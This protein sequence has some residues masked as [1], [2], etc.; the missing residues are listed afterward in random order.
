MAELTTYHRK[1]EG[2][3]HDDPPPSYSDTTFAQ[4]S[5]EFN[6]AQPSDPLLSNDIAMP[7]VA[8]G[9]DIAVLT[10]EDEVGIETGEKVVE[11]E[12]EEVS[13]REDHC[14]KAVGRVQDAVYGFF[15]GNSG[16]LWKIFYLVLLV[17]Y[18]VYFIAAMA[19]KFGDEGSI[20]LLVVTLLVSVY[21]LF[22][23]G[24]FLVRRGTITCCD[25]SGASECFMNFAKKIKLHMALPVVVMLSALIYIIVDVSLHHPRNLISLGGMV[26]F[27]LLF[28]VFSHNPARVQWRPVVWG[29]SLQFFFAVLILRTAWGYKAFDY[30]GARVTDLLAYTDAGSKFVFGNLYTNHFFAFK[31]LPVVVFF[32]TLVSMM[33]YVG[34]MQFIIRNLGRFLA[35]CLG[36]SPAESLNAAG[37]IFIGQSEAP[38]MI[39]PFISEMTKSELHAVLTGGFATIAGSVMAAFILYGVSPNHLLSAS[40]MSAPAALA[41][42]K[43]FYP[44]TKRTRHTQEEVYNMKRGEERN[45][46]DAASN[47]ATQSVKLVANI[48]VIL[49]AFIALLDFVNATLVWFGERV[50]VHDPKLTFQ[51]ISSYVFFPL[52]FLMGVDGE[53]GL[54][55]GELIGTKTF[56][57][58]FV[59]Y[60]EL[61][62]YINNRKTLNT[63]L[64]NFTLGL[65]TNPTGNYSFVDGGVFLADINQTL[66]KGLM[67]ERSVVI[68]TYAL[69]GFSN[70]GSMGLMLGT[71]GGMA[72]SRRSDISELV[73]R[74]MIAGNVACFMTACIAGLL[75]T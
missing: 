32:S 23:L 6:D 25:C 8:P 40:V 21:L 63:Y 39:R 7:P 62:V 18:L 47:G 73:F 68:S 10:G 2:I 19:Y 36:T 26:V 60:T 53:D 43:L 12:E 5:K 49:I 44:E 37:N 14:S 65:P 52:S 70:F 15:T 35:F 22:R 75:T 58:E 4:N 57:N 33:Y 34:F 67:T 29:I 59:A 45:I 20:R 56:L 50:G 55:M 11:G 72:P 31:V 64:R 74:A 51:L 61:S 28:Y 41:M 69:C 54:K 42:S 13:G 66:A 48:A 16:L 30:L 46:I 1:P 3:K 9:D 38:L 17:L 24:E 27:I 71:L